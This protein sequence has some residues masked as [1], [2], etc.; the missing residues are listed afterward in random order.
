MA[1]YAESSARK[2]KSI[3]ERA[4]LKLGYIDVISIFLNV[5][6]FASVRLYFCAVYNTI[7]YT[8]HQIMTKCL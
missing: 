7:N 1:R 6:V 8:S 3:F 4:M 2:F 5:K